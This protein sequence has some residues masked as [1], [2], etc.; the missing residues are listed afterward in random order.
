VTIIELNKLAEELN[1]K[2]LIEIYDKGFISIILSIDKYIS[3]EFHVTFKNNLS[4]IDYINHKLDDYCLIINKSDDNSDDDLIMEFKL[5]PGIDV[6]KSI[7]KNKI[8]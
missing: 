2:T 7:I 8:I 4:L 5:L 6:M 1:L 3:V